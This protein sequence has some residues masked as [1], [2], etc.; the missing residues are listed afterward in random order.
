MGMASNI[1]WF[2]TPLLSLEFL[3]TLAAAKLM[4]THGPRFLYSLSYIG[5]IVA[6]IA[7]GITYFMH[8]KNPLTILIIITIVY[9]LSRGILESCNT[10][11]RFPIYP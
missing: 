6:L 9:Q 4:I 8:V 11:E 1:P 10:M 2:S 7:Y 3:S 5:I